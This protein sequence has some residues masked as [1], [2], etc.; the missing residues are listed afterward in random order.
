M[1]AVAVNA[2]NALAQHE[3]QQLC[4]LRWKLQQHPV[5]AGPQRT[6]P[7]IRDA[8]LKKTRAGAGPHGVVPAKAEVGRQIPIWIQGEGGRG[9]RVIQTIRGAEVAGNLGLAQDGPLEKRGRQGGGG[10]VREAIAE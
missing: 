3:H 5:P 4:L 8:R 9:F 2:E 6:P 10:G 1:A 7:G